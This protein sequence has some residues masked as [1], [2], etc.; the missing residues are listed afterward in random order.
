MN[1]IRY[2]GYYY[3]EETG[4]YYLK[5]RYYDP[6][7]GRFMTIDDI[8]YIDPETINGLNLYAYCANNPIANVDPNG[9]AWWHWLVAGV[10]IANDIGL[11]DL[12]G[13]DS[14]IGSPVFNEFMSKAGKLATRALGSWAKSLMYAITSSSI[15]SII[16]GWF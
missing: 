6:E 13:I 9:N 10:A 14:G 2:R 12:I 1:P 15:S 7:I 5:T 8:S 16:S 4:L 11:E 3:D